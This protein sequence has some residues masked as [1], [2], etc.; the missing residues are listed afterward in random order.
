MQVIVS[1][2]RLLRGGLKARMQLRRPG[3]ASR[4]SQSGVTIA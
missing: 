4:A 1:I 2:L 3:V